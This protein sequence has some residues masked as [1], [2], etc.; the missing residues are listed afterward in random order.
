MLKTTA[1]SSPPKQR[2]V[3]PTLEWQPVWR[4]VTAQIGSFP[5]SGVTDPKETK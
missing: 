5:P 1:M 2:Y 3:P 4:V